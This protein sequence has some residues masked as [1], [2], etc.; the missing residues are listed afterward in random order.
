VTPASRARPKVIPSCRVPAL[1]PFSTR[2][3]FTYKLTLLHLWC[4][5]RFRS[6][7]RFDAHMSTDAE[8]DV[9][10]IDVDATTNSSGASSVVFTLNIYGY[11]IDS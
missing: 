7:S 4:V 8:V 2:E 1:S 3:C 6:C 9:S 5:I 10:S 11:M